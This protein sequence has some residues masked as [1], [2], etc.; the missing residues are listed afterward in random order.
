M[1]P[2]RLGQNFLVDKSVAENIVCS[3][4]LSCED[5]VI[6]I[7]PGKGILTGLIAPLVKKLICVEIDPGLA[8]Q[9]KEK[10][11]NCKN[12]EIV[13]RD[14]LRWPIPTA[15]Q[16]GSAVKFISNLPYYITSPIL[17]LALSYDNWQTAVF[18]VQKEVG[19]RILAA[20]GCREYGVLTLMVLF[21]AQPGK[22]FDVSR[23]SFSPV[24]EVDSTV[25]KFTRKTP[26]E[27]CYP[28]TEKLF[29]RVI[30]SA[31]SQRRKTVLNSMSAGLI[32]PKNQ[33]TELLVKNG[34]DP[35]IRPE[36]I[37]FDKF[38]SLAIDLKTVI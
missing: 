23:A 38:I 29:H 14:F 31:F 8:F 21:H 35:G 32:L 15:S 28:V 5:T 1:K 7:G 2:T 37:P 26:R 11:G 10:F 25:I 3:A 33:I 24:P 36:H 17:N 13:T 16:T 27:R 12:V 18:M 20:P 4:E 6:E 9:L 22:L 34:V 19:E 30:K